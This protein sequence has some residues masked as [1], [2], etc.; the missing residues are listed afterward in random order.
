VEPRQ[1]ERFTALVSRRAAGEPIAYL[2]GRREFWSLSLTVTSQTLIPRPETETLVALALEKMP[3]DRT[4]HI[5][6]L[7]TGTG[8][9]ALAVAHERPCSEVIATD[10]SLAALSVARG[11]AAR[12]GLGNVCF[13]GASWCRA[14]A[15]AAFD[16]ILSNPPYVT[17]SDPHLGTGDLRFE[18]RTALAA[19]PEGMDALRR[20]VPG[21]HDLLRRDGWLIVEHGHDQGDAVMQLMSTQGF[22]EISDHRDA[23]GLSRVTMGR[24]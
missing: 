2:L 20:I 23:A 19:G 6:D 5:A 3:V 7:G 10:I 11:N 21:A 16:I 8:A 14:F 12:L 24:R 1:Q 9:I 17:E 22:R 13:A 4:L 15:A 18:P